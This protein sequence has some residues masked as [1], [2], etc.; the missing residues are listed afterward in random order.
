MLSSLKTWLLTGIAAAFGILVAM[1]KWSES[2]RDKAIQRA[3]KAER[4]IVEQTEIA[5]QQSDLARAQN[6]SRQKAAEHEVSKTTERP[7]GDFGYDRL[8]D[9]TRD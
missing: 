3:E 8:R 9:E 5:N 7:S 2:K 4:E 1:L 6:E